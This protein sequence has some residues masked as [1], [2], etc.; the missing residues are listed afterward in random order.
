[1]WKNKTKRVDIRGVWK[2]KEKFLGEKFYNKKWV[3]VIFVYENKKKSDEKM[4]VK[5]D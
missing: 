5:F 3:L 2:N 4:K 1:M